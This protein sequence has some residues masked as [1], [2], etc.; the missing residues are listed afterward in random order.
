MPLP[1]PKPPHLRAFT[2]VELM[3]AVAVLAVLAALAVPSFQYVN[4]ASRLS[5]MA[6]ELVASL[7]VARSEAI[8]RGV[9]TVICPSTDGVACI[10]GSDWS[11]GWMLFFDDNR[12]NT[13]D[14]GETVLRY[15]LGRAPLLINTSGNIGARLTFR[16]DGR[17]YTNAGALLQAQIGVCIATTKPAENQR[18]VSI[19][20]GSRF[21]VVRVNGGG[22]CAA[23]A[24]T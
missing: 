4:N 24:N 6:N 8:R 14:A 2:L 9:R 19:D 22:A 12:N 3:I 20:F 1:V 5:G 21:N 16:A 10:A 18:N 7:Q 13:P 17:A 15:V 11:A 23:P